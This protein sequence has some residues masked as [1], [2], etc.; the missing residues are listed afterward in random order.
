M[1]WPLTSGANHDL[2][3]GRPGKLGKATSVDQSNPV[4][5]SHNVSVRTAPGSSS[6]TQINQIST[7][8]LLGALGLVL[9]AIALLGLGLVSVSNQAAT[10]TGIA[11]QAERQAQNAER[12]AR[13]AMDKAEELRVMNG[14][15][16]ALISGYLGKGK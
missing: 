16:T 14:V 5:K 1:R 8:A 11:N 13:V 7:W 12:E 3:N 6:V 2:E 9:L 15:N 10:A 4:E